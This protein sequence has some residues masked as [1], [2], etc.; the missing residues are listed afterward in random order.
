[1]ANYALEDKNAMNTIRDGCIKVVVDG[2]PWYDTEWL[3][4]CSSVQWEVKYLRTRGLLTHHPLIP[5][6]I[7][8]K[9]DT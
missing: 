1:V 5:K 2:V 3:H 6:L 4:Y 8:L 9:G 7:R